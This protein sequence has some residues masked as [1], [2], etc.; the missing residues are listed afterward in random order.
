[1]YKFL[2]KLLPPKTDEDVGNFHHRKWY[3]HLAENDNVFHRYDVE[4]HCTGYEC[5]PAET[6]LGSPG[7]GS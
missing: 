6:L 4:C 7:F 1:M 5:P 3:G 2:L